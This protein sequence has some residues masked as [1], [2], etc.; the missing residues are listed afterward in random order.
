M[1]TKLIKA[2]E[3]FQ[4]NVSEFIESVGAKLKDDSYILITPIGKL[5]IRIFECWIACRFEDVCAATVFTKG[6]SNP[7][8]GKWNWLYHNDVGTLNNGLVIADFVHAIERLLA[9]IPTEEDSVEAERLR[10]A[11]MI[12]HRLSKQ[13][14]E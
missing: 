11:A 3:F 5:N 13:C 9:H 10:N 1:T 6:L 12:R 2:Q 14:R 4:R 7:F 8:S